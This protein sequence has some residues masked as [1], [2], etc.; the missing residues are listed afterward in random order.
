MRIPNNQ[1]L[2]VIREIP[3]KILNILNLMG[4]PNSRH[5]GNSQLTLN[6]LSNINLNNSRILY[7]LWGT[8]GFK[9]INMLE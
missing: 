1:I 7:N 6:L 2:L 4:I 5:M 8:I 9:I 3:N